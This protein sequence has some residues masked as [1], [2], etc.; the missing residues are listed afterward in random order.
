VRV[1]VCGGRDFHRYPRVAAALDALHR[2]R[3]ISVLIEGGAPGADELA[4]SWAEARGIHCAKVSARWKRYGLSA[5]P[6]RNAAM[7]AL[8]PDLVVAFP[9]DKGTRNMITQSEACGA[10]V[11]II[12]LD[13]EIEVPQ[14]VK[15]A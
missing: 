9:G 11:W 12:P 10:P 15:R 2:A 8:N 4:S 14:H 3:P 6:L 13:G 7:L 5:G 1:L